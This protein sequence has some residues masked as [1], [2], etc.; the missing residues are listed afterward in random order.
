MKEMT[1][2]GILTVVS[3]FSGAGKGTLMKELLKNYDNYALSISATT[4]KPREG[5]VDGREYFFITRETFTGMIENN[6]LIE[7]ANYVNN[8]YG[9]P[10]TYVEE[11]LF[12]GKDV[13]LEIE[14]QG[15]LKIKEKYPD[16]LLLFVLPPNASELSRRLKGR[17]TEDLDTIN[18]RLARACE[19]A[20]GVE[21]YDYLIIND[22]L[23]ECVRRMHQIIQNE[24]CRAFRN[25]VLIE[26]IREELKGFSKGE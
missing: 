2:K 6:E 20:E 13:I 21:K 22:N 7:Y 1:K 11:Q 3:G 5:E 23:E 9:T 19:E 17:G 8:F 10:R 26:N 14:I 12:R 15:A 4:R 18:Q 16:S 24:H 25:M